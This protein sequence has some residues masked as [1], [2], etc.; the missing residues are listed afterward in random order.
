MEEIMIWHNPR[1]RKS[2][3]GLEY[4][5][6]RGIEPK[7]FLYL[8]QPFTKEELVTIIQNSGQPLKDF[9]RTNEK[10]FKQLGKDVKDLTIEEFAELAVQFPKILQRPIV[11]KG[12]RAVLARPANRID[13]IL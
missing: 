10:E 8:E 2:R 1:C 13:E 4:L 6:S 5:K 9:V 7:V 11:V 3:E 12:E